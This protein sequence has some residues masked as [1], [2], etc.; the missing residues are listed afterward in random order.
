MFRQLFVNFT[1]II[2]AISITAHMF[3][4]KEL[5]HSSPI[6]SRIIFGICSG[7]LGIILMIFSIQVLP[8]IIVDF[9]NVAAIWSAIYGGPVSAIITCMIIGSFRVL[10][11][12]LTDS[13]IAALINISFMAIGFSFIC[14]QSFSMRKK[15]AICVIYAIFISS[16]AF[17]LVLTNNNVLVK[18]LL[19][20][21]IG[22]IIVTYFMYYLTEF[23]IKLNSLYRKFRSEA[24]QDFLTGLNNVRGFDEEINFLMNNSKQTSHVV[25]L[26]FIDIDFFKKINDTYG[27]IAGDAILIELADLLPKLC[28]YKD[29]VSRN[30]GEEFSI[31]LRDCPLSKAIEVAERIRSII[32]KYPFKLLNNNIINITVSIGVANYPD[33]IDEINKLIEKADTSLYKAKR[34]GRNKVSIIQDDEGLCPNT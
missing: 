30:G 14:R 28:S 5:V 26:L 20:F 17:Y 29:T 4:E 11:F 16:I 24:K 10:Y 2:S 27:H 32:E 12:G 3:R 18:V 13:S 8:N 22:T 9:R 21:S 7:V 33:T 23:H 19:Y 1:I 31:I 6:S 25:S 15:Y 34:T